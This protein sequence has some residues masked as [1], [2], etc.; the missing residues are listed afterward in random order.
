M[1]FLFNIV[2][3]AFYAEYMIED[4]SY[5]DVDMAEFIEPTP[6]ELATYH[7]T[8]P[9]T[10]QRLGT[11]NG[12]PG[13]IDLP[14]LSSEES[15]ALAEAER[16]RLRVIADSEIAW[17]QDAV[18]ADIATDEEKAALAAWRKY[19]VLLMRVDTAAPV[20]PTAPEV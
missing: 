8:T 7:K 12:R 9:P 3:A 15:A 20:W 6:A 19:R 16:G 17:R 14:P 18:D 10:G 5:G 2:T 1:Q 13:W 4:G 11:V